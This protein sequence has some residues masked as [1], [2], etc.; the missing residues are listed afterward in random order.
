VDRPPRDARTPHGL[1]RTENA[2]QALEALW[3]AIQPA[4]SIVEWCRR[5]DLNDQTVKQVLSGVKIMPPK[6]AAA[7][8]YRCMR[9]VRYEK[10]KPKA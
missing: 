4:G 5:N 6:V 3:R 2:P 9:I 10:I 8:G 1:D 7:I